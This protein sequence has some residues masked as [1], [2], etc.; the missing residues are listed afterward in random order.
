MDLGLRGKRA[1][2]TGA[3]KGI[4]RRII[5]QLVKEGCNVA[6]CSRT[7][8]DVEDTIDQFAHK[9]AEVMGA[10]CDIG[11]KAEYEAWIN[12][13]VERMD[14]VDVFIPTVSA[15]GGMDSEKNWWK[16][17]E[18]DVLGTVRGCEAVIPHMHESGGGAITLISTTAAVETFAQPQAYNAMKAGLITYGKQLGQFCGKDNIRVNTVS[19]GPIEFP[20]GVWDMLKDTMPKWYEKTAREHPTERLGTPEEVARCVVFISSP[21]ASWVNGV[22]FVV[23]GGYTKRVQF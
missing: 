5:E 8:E 11:V 17:F 13:M 3:T 10:V 19:P 1:I 18:V 16:N 9:K 23:D 12:D 4:G 7:E 22:N 15:G 14:G 2:V 20:G 6:I 21:A